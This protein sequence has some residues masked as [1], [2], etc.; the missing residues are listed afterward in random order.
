MKLIYRFSGALWVMFGSSLLGLALWALSAQAQVMAFL[1]G[2][3]PIPLI[4]TQSS[5]GLLPQTLLALL[6]SVFCVVYGGG[7]IALKPWARGIGIATNIL[8]GVILIVLTLIVYNQLLT[9]N[10]VRSQL[11]E[12]LPTV[13]VVGGVIGG[14]MLVLLGF[15]LGTLSTIDVFFGGP[16]LRSA[17]ITSPICPT[18]NETPMNV[19][20]AMCPKCDVEKRV[21]F[22]SAKLVN[23]KDSTQIFNVNL[24]RENTVGAAKDR[25]IKLTYAGVGN[26]HAFIE[27]HERDN[28]GRFYLHAQS[29]INGT[30]V[31]A[32][33]IRDAQ[34]RHGD[35]IAFGPPDRVPVFRFE[36]GT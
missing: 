11:P 16:I 17:N 18:C 33:K 20:K 32:K 4:N 10:L 13:I 12:W 26:E 1:Y 28:E 9:L 6:F 36:I 2:L 35:E 27:Y 7:M 21:G 31:N 3:L 23:L 34:I 8:T 5:M 29:D 25:N 22:T 15:Q 14:L 30:F 24:V 19:A